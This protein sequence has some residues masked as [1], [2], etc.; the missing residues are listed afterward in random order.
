VLDSGDAPVP[1][2]VARAVA[3]MSAHDAVYHVLDH[4]QAKNSRFPG[5]NGAVYFESWHTSDGGLHQKMFADRHGHQGRLLNDFAGRK[6]PGRRGGPALSWDARNNTIFSMRFGTSPGGGGAPS[7]DPYADPGATLRALEAAGG[8]RLAGRVEVDGRHAYRLVSGPVRRPHGEM[9]ERVEFIVDAE[10]YLPL[11]S[12]F[13]TR[14]GAGDSLELFTR[15]LVYERLPLNARSRA[16][17]D[18][19]PHPGAK[20]APGAGKTIGR[21]TLG[22]PNPCAR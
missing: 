13:V 4:R 11:A 22:F 19:D 15:Y 16:K 14:S 18:L 10:T 2:I 20:C 21:G 7:L 8:L 17:L 1:N 3:A 12:R 5:E 6:A 9:E